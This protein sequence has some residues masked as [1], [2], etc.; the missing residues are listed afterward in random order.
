V[1]GDGDS[2]EVLDHLQ[3]LAAVVE[4]AGEDDADHARAVAPGRRPEERIDGRAKAVLARTPRHADG[5]VLDEQVAVRRRDVEPSVAE[6]FAVDRV[7]RRERPCTA[8]DLRQEPRLSGELWTTTNSAAG[9]SRGRPLAS[10][11]SAVTLPPKH[12]DHDVTGRHVRF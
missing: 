3:P 8:H 9:N 2:A 12:D 11:I 1:L 4:G 5:P 10:S 7:C 6:T